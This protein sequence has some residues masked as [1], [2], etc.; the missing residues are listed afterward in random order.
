MR[1]RRLDVNPICPETPEVHRWHLRATVTAGLLQQ[2]QF[3]LPEHHDYP[4]HL[5]STAFWSRSFCNGMTYSD[6]REIARRERN[7]SEATSAIWEKGARKCISVVRY[8]LAAESVTPPR[9]WS[10]RPLL[11]HQLSSS[12]VVHIYIYAVTK[13]LCRLIDIFDSGRF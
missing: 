9:L 2:Q 11:K 10:T 5:T 6:P 1:N 7:Y 3:L 4:G 12:I 8:A 13:F